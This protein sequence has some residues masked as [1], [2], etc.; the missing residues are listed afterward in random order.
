MNIETNRIERVKDASME[1]ELQ[2]TPKQL[3]VTMSA[4]STPPSQLQIGGETYRLVGMVDPGKALAKRV[5]NES[6]RPI[7]LGGI[8]LLGILV[9]AVIIMIARRARVK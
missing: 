9:G 8:A 7:E 1:S 6:L 5:E 3:I 2:V 4:S